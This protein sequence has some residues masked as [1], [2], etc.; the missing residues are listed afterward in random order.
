VTRATTT[1]TPSASWPATT[2][3]GCGRS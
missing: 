1:R 2:P 3:T